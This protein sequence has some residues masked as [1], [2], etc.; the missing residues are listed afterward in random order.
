MHGIIFEEIRAF[1]EAQLGDG[2]WARVRGAANLDDRTYEGIQAY[3]DEEAVALVVAASEVVGAEVGDVLESFGE[4][5]VK[6][7]ASL[8]APLLD[9]LWKALDVIE[10]AENTVHSVV[11][12]DNP[13]AEPPRLKATRISDSEVHVRYDSERRMCR[14]AIGICRGLGRHFEEELEIVHDVCM[15]RGEVYCLIKVRSR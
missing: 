1:A 9:P 7:L 12:I 8:A 10:H 15:H 3:P 13:G 11:R 4:F 6:D 2:G 5:I 14:L